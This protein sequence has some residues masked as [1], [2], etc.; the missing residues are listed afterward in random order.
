MK[1]DPNK[2]T[3]GRGRPP[4]DRFA[5]EQIALIKT[6]VERGVS[7]SRIAAQLGVSRSKFD[8]LLRQSGWTI[9]LQAH[10]VP[11]PLVTI[12]EPAAAMK[13]EG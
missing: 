3:P 2:A 4:G 5:P 13:E 8:Y 11:I 7:R 9:T 10:L 12:T 1:S 6:G